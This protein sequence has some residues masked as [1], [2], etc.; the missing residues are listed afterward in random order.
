MLVD[1]RHFIVKFSFGRYASCH[2]GDDQRLAS[3]GMPARALTSF[4]ANS[5]GRFSKL[6]IQRAKLS[7]KP[8]SSAS[9]RARFT[10]PY[11]S[12]MIA[13]KSS[14]PTMISNARDRPAKAVSHSVAH[15]MFG[16][17]FSAIGKDVKK[18]IEITKQLARFAK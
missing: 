4:F 14:A 5:S 18:M 15:I 3:E 16:H 8:S 11:F 12:A 1:N 7:T 9:G 17:V 2:N 6:A 13:S 10:Q